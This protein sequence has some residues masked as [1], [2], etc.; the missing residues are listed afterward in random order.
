MARG[1]KTAREKLEGGQ[2]PRMVDDRRGRGTMLIPK[3]LDVDT[4]MR[5]IETGKLATVTQIRDRLA[6]DFHADFT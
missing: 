4:L 5:Q 6:R 3:P 1:R 2:E